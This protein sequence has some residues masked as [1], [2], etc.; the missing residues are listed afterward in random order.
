V[1]EMHRESWTARGLRAL[2][3]TLAL[4][5]SGSRAAPP[6]A[7]TVRLD[8]PTRERVGLGVAP[9][10][11]ARVQPAVRGFGH[12]LDPTLLAQPVYDLDAARV[13]ADAAGR[14]YERTQRLARADA[15]ASRRDLENA[16]AASAQA[17]AALRTAQARVVAA[18]GPQAAER[19]DLLALARTL[20]AR[21][22]L[23]ARIDLPLGTPVGEAPTMGRLRPLAEPDADP[24]DATVLGAAPDVDPTVQ[25]RGFLLLAPHA[26]WA[27]GTAVDGWL[28][29]PGSSRTGVVVPASAL[30]RHAGD[31]WVYVQT[32]DG[33]FARR[34]VHPERPLDDGWFVADAGL[35]PGD[36]VVVTGA[37]TLLSTELGGT[38]EE[39]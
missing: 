21:E 24:L 22:A 28:Q 25:G 6:D 34:Q 8:A 9:L 10:V 1:I 39:D 30:V 3:A 2:V 37:Q 12:V 14:E 11:A 7:G 17:Q 31:T 5:G 33:V 35:A 20:I 27:P 29:L 15:N 16:R 19:E 36:P 13:A 18:W 38:V 23:L 4:A 32:S 26:T